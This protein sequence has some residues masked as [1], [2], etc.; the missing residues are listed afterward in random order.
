MYQALYRKWR[1][2]DFSDVYGQPHVTKTLRSQLENGRIS[3]AYL[4]CGPRGTGKTTCAKIIAKAANCENPVGGNPCGVCG[5]CKAFDS[6]NAPDIIEMDAASNNGVDNIRDIRDEVAFAPSILKYRVYIVDEVHMLSQAAFNAFLKT[7]E[8][9]PAHAIFILATTEKHKILPT[10]LSRC[11]TYDFNRITVEN[12]LDIKQNKYDNSLA[13]TNK[14]VVPAINELLSAIN[15]INT[16]IGGLKYNL[17]TLENN[18]GIQSPGYN[19]FC[20]A[21]VTRGDAGLYVGSWSDLTTIKSSTGINATYLSGPNRI[22]LSNTSGT[23]HTVVFI[24][25]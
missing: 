3:H 6:G 13:T 10:I 11:Q 12:I 22:Q 19:T 5:S 18:D 24:Y 2:K 23:T 4:F 21:F 15:T 25:Q 7:L 20:I 16:D 8:E 9:P 14:Q 17:R 1:P